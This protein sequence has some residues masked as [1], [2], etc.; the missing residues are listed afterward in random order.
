[1]FTL[2]VERKLGISEYTLFK[3]TGTIVETLSIQN[4]KQEGK[5][6]L[7]KCRYFP[8]KIFA[9]FHVSVHSQFFISYPVECECVSFVI[10]AK[11]HPRHLSQSNT[12]VFSIP[13]R[14]NFIPPPPPPNSHYRYWIG[15]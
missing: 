5:A 1:M 11:R 4:E 6:V 9:V 7:E 2:V 10:F 14:L 15:T 13:N 12:G 3:N 8:N